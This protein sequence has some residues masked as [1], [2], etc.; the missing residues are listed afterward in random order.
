MHKSVMLPLPMKILNQHVAHTLYF[1]C[2]VYIKLILVN[3]TS[4]NN[5]IAQVGSSSTPREIH[6]AGVQFKCGPNADYPD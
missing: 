4:N 2:T 1:F 6:S 5:L 3:E